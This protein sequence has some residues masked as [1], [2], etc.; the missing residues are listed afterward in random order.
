MNFIQ[1]FGTHVIYYISY[2]AQIELDSQVE[3]CEVKSEGLTSL[4]TDVDII[5]L[6]FSGQING[7][8]SVSSLDQQIFQNS[9]LTCTGGDHTFCQNGAPV[10]CNWGLLKTSLNVT[11]LG[12]ITMQVFPI[13]SVV[14][15]ASLSSNLAL[16][17]SDYLSI[18]Q[19]DISPTCSSAVSLGVFWLQFLKLLFS[20]II[21]G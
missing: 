3:E 21:H 4:A 10:D 16:A 18:E 19:P 1:N 20:W 15:D 8:V 7:S 17:V 6:N 12:I 5:F 14:A 13:Q 2:G 11:N 9:E